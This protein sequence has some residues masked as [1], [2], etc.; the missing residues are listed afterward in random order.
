[1]SNEKRV[2]SLTPEEARVRFVSDAEEL[3]RKFWAV[4]GNPAPY[5]DKAVAQELRQAIQETLICLDLSRTVQSPGKTAQDNSSQAD[6]AAHADF[7]AYLL[8]G[9]SSGNYDYVRKVCDDLGAED[10]PQA[11]YTAGSTEALSLLTYVVEAIEQ[12]HHRSDD[13]AVLIVWGAERQEG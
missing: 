4:L 10:T 7:I 13:V 12:A 5:K 3:L 6:Y 11:R 9:L 8:K 2:A 1:M